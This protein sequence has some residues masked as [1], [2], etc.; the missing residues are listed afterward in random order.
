[1]FLSYTASGIVKSAR[2]K[3]NKSARIK[4]QELENRSGSL[5]FYLIT[6][7]LHFDGI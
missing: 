3:K 5:K 6:S 1:M 4:V 2:T 7:F